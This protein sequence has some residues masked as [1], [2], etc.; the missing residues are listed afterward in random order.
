MLE[1]I[2]EGRVT[3]HFSTFSSRTQ[4]WEGINEH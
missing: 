1:L 2:F 4:D 3:A